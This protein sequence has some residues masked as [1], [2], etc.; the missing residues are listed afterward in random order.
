MFWLKFCLFL[1]LILPLHATPIKKCKN[2]IVR[3]EW[4]TLSTP[5]KRSYISAVK[6]LLK[7]PALTTKSDLPGVTNR[8]ED[9]LGTHI[10]QTSTVHFVGIFY[11][12]HRLF[13]H[14]YEKELQ[15]CGY[16]GA[17]PYWDWTLDTH[18]PVTFFNSPIFDIKTGF[19]GNGDW[20]PGNVSHPADGMI[21]TSG[22]FDIADRT[23]GGCVPNGPFKGMINNLGP[24][25]AVD[26]NPHCVRRDFS[27]SSFNRSSM[28][29]VLQGMALP[30]FGLF[31]RTTEV[32]FHGGGHLG[33]GGIYGTLT[34]GYSSPGDPI[35]YLHH[36]NMDRAWWSW[37]KRD[38]DSR[39]NDM[40]GPLVKQDYDNKVAGNATLD[41]VMH[42][43]TTV[44]I[45]AP[46]R[47]VMHIQQGILCY[48]YDE[49]Y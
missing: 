6:C 26:Y 49:L 24:N 22:G 8:F 28:E 21:V 30:N 2:P 12:W 29:N 45:T 46:V 27:P 25:D 20:V 37:Q 9:F 48:T 43:G 36:A 7:K 10:L 41:T 18:S 11:P 34:D 5:E 19:G 35:F 42:V 16:K 33:V 44:N 32:T 1:F 40:S 15:A 17:Q 14:E 13:L 3:K 38:L 39:L 47:D 23:G 4:R 31:D